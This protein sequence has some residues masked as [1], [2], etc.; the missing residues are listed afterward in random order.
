MTVMSTI[1]KKLSPLLFESDASNVENT[2]MGWLESG[3]TTRVVRGRKMRTTS[4]L[5]NEFSAALQFP[6]YFGENWAAFDECLSEPESLPPGKGYIIVVTEPNEVLAEEE[7]RLFDI[8]AESLTSAAQVFGES[9]E[10]GESWD[11]AAVAF[12]VVLAGDPDSLAVAARRW[13]DA[14]VVTNPFTFD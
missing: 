9:I 14:G 6:R 10:L 13:S 1:D 5:F 3:F 4:D 7:T 2:V 8:F 11:R 12:H